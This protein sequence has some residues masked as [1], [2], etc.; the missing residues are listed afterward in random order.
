MIEKKEKEREKEREKEGKKEREEERVDFKANR[1][2]LSLIKES[3]FHRKVKVESFKAS[4]R[5][6]FM[7]GHYSVQCDS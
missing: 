7:T 4:V 3:Y 2:A 5:P 1:C 6:I